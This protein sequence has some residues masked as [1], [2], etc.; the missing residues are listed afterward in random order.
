MYVCLFVCLLLHNGYITYRNNSPLI[1]GVILNKGDAA[2]LVNVHMVFFFNDSY[3]FPSFT[4]P[5][6]IPSSP[7][8]Q[9]F[10]PASSFFSFAE[11]NFHRLLNI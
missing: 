2:L 1:G 7:F 6:P 10:P 3:T 9:S 4:L 11:A 8:S 5:L